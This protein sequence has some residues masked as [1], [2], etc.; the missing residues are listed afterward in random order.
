MYFSDFLKCISLWALLLRTTLISQFWLSLWPLSMEFPP[1]LCTTIISWH[2]TISDLSVLS[3]LST[4][5][6]NFSFSP[7]YF[8][9]ELENIVFLYLFHHYFL[10]SYGFPGGSDDKEPT[11]SAEDPGTIPGLGRFPWRRDWLLTPVFLPLEFHGQ[12]SLIGYSL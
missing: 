5:S 4:H 11:C 6:V 1:F 10:F 9:I 12:R 3:W 2:R 8:F 7:L